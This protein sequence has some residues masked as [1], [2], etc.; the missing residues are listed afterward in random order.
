MALSKKR[1]TRKAHTKT[2]NGKSVAI[3]EG[4][5]H[6][7]AKDGT[8]ATS[9]KEKSAALKNAMNQLD[10]IGTV[11]NNW[12]MMDPRSGVPNPTDEEKTYFSQH[13][14]DFA[15]EAYMHEKR[16]RLAMGNNEPIVL[17]KGGT[18]FTSEL[19]AD[20]KKTAPPT[21]KIEPMADGATDS[22]VRLDL[23]SETVTSRLAEAPIFEKTAMVQAEQVQEERE[24]RTV[25]KDGTEE[26]VNIAKPGDYIVTNPG[27]EQYVM[28]QENFDK[29]YAAYEGSGWGNEPSNTYQAKGSVRAIQ[30]PTGQPIT[31]TAPWGEEQ[32]G[33]ERCYVVSAYDP[34]KPNEVSGD[35]YIIG[36]DEFH[37]TYGQRDS[38]W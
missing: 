15:K 38:S 18:D 37:E 16:H 29:R 20:M 21:M 2:V 22:P 12:G 28:S 17:P 3:P 32:H 4:D 9:Q 23:S 36:Y 25:L 1:T 8:G 24:V 34:N 10:S 35:R 33:D 30:N 31:I 26:T 14:G 19:A 11:N 13:Y 27:G 6:V 5:T 7:W